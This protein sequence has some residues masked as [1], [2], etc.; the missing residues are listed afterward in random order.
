MGLWAAVT[1]LIGFGCMQS[2]LADLGCP[3]SPSRRAWSFLIPLGPLL[4]CGGWSEYQV[5]TVA[6]WSSMPLGGLQDLV[7]RGGHRGSHRQGTAGA[8]ALPRS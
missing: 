3:A 1:A 6:C 5:R 4:V 7:G 2:D 8:P